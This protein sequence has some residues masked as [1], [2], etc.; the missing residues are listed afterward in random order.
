MAE[1]LFGTDGIRGVANQYPVSCEIAIKIGRAA[2]LLVKRNGKKTII[3]GKDTRQS[4]DMLEAALTSGIVSTGVD[5]KIA[6]VIPTPGVA[7]LATNLKNAGAGIVISASH[8][9][10]Q[11]NGIKIFNGL[12]KKLNDQDQVFIEDL[13][14]NNESYIGT[15]DIGKIS[16]IDDAVVQYADFLKS[17][18]DFELLR[19]KI[20]IIVDCS[21]GAAV[22]TVPKVFED[23][24]FK[25][26]F[27]F[28]R[29]D[30]KNINENCGSQFTQSLSKKV[31]EEGYDIGLGLDGDADRL[32]AIDEKGNEVKGDKILAICTKFLKEQGALDNNTVVSTIMSNVGLIK[33]LKE[34]GV[35]HRITDVGDA[36]VI[37]EMKNCGAI[38]GGEDSGHLIFSKYHTTGDGI[39]SA[40]RIIEV[41]AATEKPLSELSKVMKTYPQVLMNVEV[42]SSRPDYMK[43]K[44]ISEK[45]KNVENKL[46]QNGRVLIRYSGTQP[47]LRVM[48]EGPDKKTIKDYC[49][50]ICKKIVVYI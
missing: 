22:N 39:L 45:I 7:F 25:T 29:P 15:D 4:G 30:G 46:G 23:K 10:Y 34:S 13:I 37:K 49:E 6:G 8:N 3:I 9:P 42:D 43:I 33:Y 41:M 16:C 35:E 32:I 28:N 50:Q 20:K 47:L 14:N 1:K 26:K 24:H 48:I 19:K 17:T 2:G 21:N 44:E 40:L 11:D 12:G 27:I 5:A 36:N 18:L 38:I 31:I